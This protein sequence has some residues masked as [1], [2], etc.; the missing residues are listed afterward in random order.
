MSFLSCLLTFKWEIS[1]ATNCVKRCYNTTNFRERPLFMCKR[2][3]ANGVF[4]WKKRNRLKQL[5]LQFIWAIR[6]QDMSF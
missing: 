4:G 3:T 5:L 6:N 1:L 2:G